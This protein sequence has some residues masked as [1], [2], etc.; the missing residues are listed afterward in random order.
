[1]NASAPTARKF[2]N[3]YESN[4]SK[5]SS[6]SPV[7]LMCLSRFGSQISCQCADLLQGWVMHLLFTRL[8]GKAGSNHPPVASSQNFPSRIEIS[9]CT[10]CPPSLL[11]LRFFSLWGVKS[12]GLTC[13]PLTIC[14]VEDTWPV[15]PTCL[16]DDQK[17]YIRDNTQAQR[18]ISGGSLPILSHW[19]VTHK[20]FSS[21]S[22]V[23]YH[24]S[25]FNKDDLQTTQSAMD[26][27]SKHYDTLKPICVQVQVS[28]EDRDRLRKEEIEALQEVHS[29]LDQLQE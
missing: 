15:S 8:S 12:K 1:M 13:V 4:L 6:A 21:C 24:C 7:I 26:A 28:F 20:P 5:T 11:R 22:I 3:L 25:F 2:E 17:E 9:S 10:I 29:L 19:G 16:P 18:V 27:A 23:S 14:I